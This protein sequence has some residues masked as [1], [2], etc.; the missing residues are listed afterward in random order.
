M[1]PLALSCDFQSGPATWGIARRTRQAPRTTAGAP[2]PAQRWAG[3]TAFASCTLPRALAAPQRAP[4]PLSSLTCSAHLGPLQAQAVPLAAQAARTARAACLPGRSGVGRGGHPK[5]IGHWIDGQV[6]Q[7]PWRGRPGLQPPAPDR[8]W[9]PAPSLQRL[10]RLLMPLVPRTSRAPCPA[11]VLGFSTARTI[12]MPS[13][14]P[15]RVSALDQ[16]AS[17]FTSRWPGGRARRSSEQG[18]R[19]PDQAYSAHY[20]TAAVRCCTASGRALSHA[21]AVL[22]PL[23]LLSRVRT[24]TAA[25]LPSS[26]ARM[27][28]RARKPAQLVSWPALRLSSSRARTPAPRHPAHS[29][30]CGARRIGARGRVQLLLRINVPDPVPFS[31]SPLCVN[32]SFSAPAC[33]T[34]P[35]TA[36]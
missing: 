4:A 12:C 20:R 29:H 15:A 25:R 6:R 8:R 26:Q 10:Q 36:C 35:T 11:C 1:L 24:L 18:R 30:R 31:S 13:S 21:R 2:P 33:P 28:R 14:Q 27:A 7:K 34:S 9:R 23:C 19:Q 3:S 22:L 17:R 32:A 5:A 16:Q